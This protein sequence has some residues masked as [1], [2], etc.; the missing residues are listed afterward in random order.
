MKIAIKPNL[1]R[2]N[3]LEVTQAVVSML[4]SLKA[5]IYLCDEFKDEL[6]FD[7]CTFLNEESLC[8]LCDVVIAVGGDGTIIHTA[9]TCAK[10]G[11]KILGINAGRMAFMA[12]L[13]SKEIPLLSKLIT[14]EYETDK[15]MM[16]EADV[17]ENGSLVKKGF[18]INDVVIARGN[19]MKMCDIIVKCNQKHVID[20]YA[21]GLIVSTPTGSTAYSLSA[22]GPVIEPTIESVCV[23]PICAHSLFSRSII[24][25]PDSVLEISVTNPT[26]CD[27]VLSLDSE[28]TVRLNENNK[29]I[30]K[31]ADVTADFIRIKSD[32][33][34]EILSE[35]IGKK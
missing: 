12:G 22:G 8:R 18:C 9:Y 33:F 16:L 25:K 35:K 15:R 29:I 3:A 30:I 14:G 17:T 34:V 32:S 23:T 6:P 11:K 5:E 24:F 20:Y 31:K 19:T 13:E 21:D 10:Y 4:K 7:D 1:T 28:S 26:H 2:E 27:A